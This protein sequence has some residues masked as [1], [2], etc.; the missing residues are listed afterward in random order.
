MWDAI[1]DAVIDS[2]KMLPF[3]FLA[4]LLLE[5]LEHSKGQKFQNTLVKRR[6]WG[7]VGGALLG[8]IP[9]CGFSVAAA[10]LFSGR[11]I[12]AGTLVAVFISTSDEAIPILLSSPEN[13]GIVI[14]VLLWKV[15]IAVAAGLLLDFVILRK[16]KSVAVNPNNIHEYCE[17]HMSARGILVAALKHTCYI[18]LFILAVLLALNT[19][20][21]LIGE[22]RLA[23]ILMSNTLLQPVIAG[24]I[25]FIPNCAPSVILTQLYVAGSLSFG[26][27]L[28]GLITAGGM[29]IVVLL[30]SNRNLKQNLGLLGYIYLIAV[31]TGIVLF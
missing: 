28:S 9:Q 8:C 5:Y 15:G 16:N 24:L 23:S 11:V 26:S 1:L 3:L 6:K 7:S 4:Y 2:L 22:E 12:T 21:Y 10:N 17:E 14:K 29:G 25:G 31:V 30:K 18:S 13:A 27:L 19:A 20:I